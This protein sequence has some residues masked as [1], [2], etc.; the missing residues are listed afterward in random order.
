MIRFETNQNAYANDLAD[1]VRLF[2]GMEKLSTLPDEPAETVITHEFSEENGQWVQR[3]AID[4]PG[5]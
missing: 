5:G 4:G 3:C 2:F 1:V